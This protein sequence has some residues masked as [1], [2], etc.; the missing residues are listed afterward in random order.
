MKLLEAQKL[1]YSLQGD[2]AKTQVFRSLKAGDIVAVYER[3]IDE[4]KKERIQKFQGI[5]IRKRRSLL[6]ENILLREKFRNFWV[7]KSFFIHSPSV[8]NIERVKEG[9]SRR[10]Y[11]SYLRTTESLPLKLKRLKPRSSIVKK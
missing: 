5:L 3:L 9:R 2:E 8:R 11:L 4:K 10:A 1:F 6:G 7:E